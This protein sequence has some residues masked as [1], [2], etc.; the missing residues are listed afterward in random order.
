MSGS[1]C[2]TSVTQ[3]MST[4]RRCVFGRS[5]SKN[6]R[7]AHRMNPNACAWPG[8]RGHTRVPEPSLKRTFRAI[9]HGR[10]FVRHGEH[11]RARFAG[12]TRWAD[13]KSRDLRTVPGRQKQ[14]ADLERPNLQLF[15][16]ELHLPPG[17]SHGHNP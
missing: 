4:D 14:H 12:S 8:L 17:V 2:G 3:G 13:H 11:E 7:C 6:S 10:Q 1:V 16:A 5:V 15:A 9:P